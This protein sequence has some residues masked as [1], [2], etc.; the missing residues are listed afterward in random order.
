MT[1]FDSTKS[2]KASGSYLRVHF[3]NTSETA[4]AIKGLSLEKAKAYLNQVLLH[5]RAIPFR[6]FSGGVGRTSQ[7]SVFGVTQGRWPK[8]S[9]E[10]VLNLL[11]NAESNAVVKGIDTE[12]LMVSRI[13]V[14]QAP[15]QRRR[16]FRAHG[17]INPYMSNP[18]HVELVLSVKEE[19]VVKAKVA[20][21]SK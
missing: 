13:Q 20:K 12:K 7:A 17:R 8:K 9:V 2:V 19:S 4:N 1:T 14:N 15:K 18:C 21:V 11:A 6:R 3:K 10:F 5:N 16:T